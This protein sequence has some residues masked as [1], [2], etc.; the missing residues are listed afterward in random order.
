MAA[1]AGLVTPMERLDTIVALAD[2]ALVASAEDFAAELLAIGETAL[3][4]WLT[5]KGRTPT[6]AR[7][8]DSA[9]WR[10]TARA[11]VATP[12]STPAARPAANSPMP[13]TA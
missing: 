4:S 9:C 8:K 13:I 6:E 12:A 5:A 10:S 11:R 2:A 7:S 3:T 1:A